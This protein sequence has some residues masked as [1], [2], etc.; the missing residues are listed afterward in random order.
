[1]KFYP[2]AEVLHQYELKPHEYIFAREVSNKSFNYYHQKEAIICSIAD[3][4]S[5]N[6]PVILSLEDKSF[7]GKYP[8]HWKI[9]QEPVNDIHS[10]MYYSKLVISSGDSMA[11]EGAMLGVP[12][13]YCGYRNMKAND[14]LIKLGL[15][16][17]LEGESSIPVLNEMLGSAFNDKLQQE[18]RESLL[19]AWDDMDLFMKNQLEK[20]SKRN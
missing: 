10:L 1:M 18:Y 16:N 14:L 20:Y 13:I 11:R 17:H 8:G 7:A 9:L 6:I 12:S 5:T 2:D 4:F 3:R 19:Y 15:L